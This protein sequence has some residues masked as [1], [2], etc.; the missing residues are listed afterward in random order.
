MLRH[1]AFFL[2]LLVL[3]ALWS[4]Q[5]EDDVPQP[6]P[7]VTG[8]PSPS[9]GSNFRIIETEFQGIP[10]VL[11]GDVN[12]GV[13]QDLPDGS[14]VQGQWRFAT[15]FL[16]E[17]DGVLLNFKAADAEMPVILEDQEGNQWDLFGEAVSGPRKGR[18]LQPVNAGMGYFFIFGAMYPGVEIAGGPAT[19]VSLDLEPAPG[20][21]IPTDFVFTGAGKDGIPSINDPQFI[22]YSADGP[23]QPG[24]YLTDEDLVVGLRIN[25]EVKAYPHPI[26]DYHEIVNDEVG[27]V[28]IALTYCPLTGTAKVWKQT[29][30]GGDPFGVSGL[31]YNSN[32]V[33]FD[34]RTD[35]EWH[36]LEGLC[37]R[38]ERIGERLEVV[39][40]VEMTWR[41]WKELFP[42][43][44]VLSTDTGVQR[45]YDDYPYGDYRTNND[46]LLVPITYDDERL[47][48][49]E[50][51][52]SIQA[53][54]TARVYRRQSFF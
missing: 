51:V 33:P 29:G 28:P 43:G 39:P 48:R 54:G 41:D 38:G 46:F 6:A 4:C 27:G 50:R 34:R 45:P 8:N 20:W 13:G 15:A 26:L 7:P 44:E 5:K 16:R 9:V 3:S 10:I 21:L 18:R 37:I 31:L 1:T 24:S 52:F 23:N 14:D 53:E 12:Q 2:F 19:D 47:P 35:S 25:G 17:L 36:Q 30:N 22:N 40:H 11:A 49:K 42:E 32:L